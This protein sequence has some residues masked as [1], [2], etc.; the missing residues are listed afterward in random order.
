MIWTFLLQRVHSHPK[1]SD[2]PVYQCEECSCQFKKLGSLN[3]HISRMHT[4]SQVISNLLVYS[5]Y[6]LT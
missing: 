3:A 4:E 5:K 6:S 2:A 1:D